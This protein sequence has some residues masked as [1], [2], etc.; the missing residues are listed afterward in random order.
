MKSNS[1]INK[2]SVL[3]ANTVSMN[4]DRFDDVILDAWKDEFARLIIE[5]CC[6]LAEYPQLDD[7]QSYY[8]NMFADHIRAYFNGT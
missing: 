6:S 2:L 8:G 3:A 1:V 5:R 4:L 7:E